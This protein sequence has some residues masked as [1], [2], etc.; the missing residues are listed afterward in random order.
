MLIEVVDQIAAR[1]PKHVKYFVIILARI[2]ENLIFI[3]LYRS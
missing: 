2:I 1:S 3:C